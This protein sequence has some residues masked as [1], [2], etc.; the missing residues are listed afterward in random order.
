MI[1]YLNF[2]FFPTKLWQSY[3]INYVRYM[4][5]SNYPK[6]KKKDFVK[7]DVSYFIGILDLQV[8]DIMSIMTYFKK[9]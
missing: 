1:F 2:P 7:F 5:L 6:Q 9:K 8:L 3:F 4:I